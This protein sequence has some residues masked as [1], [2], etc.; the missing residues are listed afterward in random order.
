MLARL[1]LLDSLE[2]GTTVQY[3]SELGFEICF[4]A[5]EDAEEEVQESQALLEE[6]FQSRWRARPHEA[7]R[8]LE[9]WLRAADAAID[10]CCAGRAA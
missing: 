5:D 9:D 3:P 4:E 8:S 2:E 6:E 10:P 7:L 1:L